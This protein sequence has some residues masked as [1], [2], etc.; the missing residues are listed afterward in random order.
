[1]K[2]SG[3]ADLP[4]HGGRV[5]AWL[6]E[7]MQKL[8]TA[9]VASII[10]HY[11]AAEFLSR[12][13][14]SFWFQA[15]GCVMG[16]DWHSSGITISVFGA[17]KRG[18]NPGAHELGI[19]ICGG[20]GKQSRKTPDELLAGADR[21]SLDGN[22]LVRTVG[23]PEDRQQRHLVEPLT[24]PENG[25][26]LA[27]YGV[28]SAHFDSNPKAAGDP[29]KK[30]AA[31][32]R[33]GKRDVRTSAVQVLQRDDGLVVVYLFPLS[34]EITKNDRRIEF[35]AQIGRVSIPQSFDLAGCF[36]GKLEL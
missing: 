14:D 33:D 18:L 17:L 23:L 16:M 24:L 27:V 1:M 35:D 32:K 19:Y 21:I 28:P 12:L 36:N 4:L 3:F 30:Q 22:A 34:A 25:Y 31:L 8:G 9:I 5:P 29:L 6:A 10:H 26:W 11:G 20:R 13:S 15:L 2:R 7:R